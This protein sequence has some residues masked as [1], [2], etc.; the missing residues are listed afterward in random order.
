MTSLR[1]TVSQA[2]G[3]RYVIE[4]ELGRG[5][6]A[7]VFLARDVK[8]RRQVAVKVL[9]QDVSAVLGAERFLREIEIAAG[10]QHP[11]ILPLHDS[12]ELDGILFYVMP[13]VE[14]ESLRSRLAREGTL[15]VQDALLITREVA[16]ALAYAHERRVIHRDIKPENILL[17]GPHAVVADF[18]IAR[19]ITSAGATSITNTGIVVGTP[20]YMSPEQ[21]AGDQSLDGRADIYA[22]GC[23]LYECLTGQPP[24]SGASAAAVLAQQ[25]TGAPPDVRRT[26]SDVSAAIQG[27]L[28][29]ALAKNPAQRFASAADFAAALSGGGLSTHTPT[30]GWRARLKTRGAAVAF[31]AAVTAAAVGGAYARRAFRTS[32]AP[33]HSLAVIPFENESPER[34]NEYFADGM[35]EELIGAFRRIAG[36]RVPPRSS[37]FAFKGS[38]LSAREVGR[39]LKVDMVLDGSVVRSSGLV[40]VRAELVDVAA[41]TTI[42][43]ESYRDTLADPFAVQDTLASRIVARLGPRLNSAA[44]TSLLRRGTSDREAYLLYLKGRYAMVPRT[45]EGL[46][47]A[48]D[49]FQQAVARD[50][51]Y[52]LAYSGLADSYGLVAGYSGALSPAE[53]FGRARVAANRALSLDAASPE[54]H[55]SSA[56]VSLFHDYDY[57]AAE[58]ELS[59]AERL[60]STYT[61]AHVIA[62]WLDAVTQKPALAV[63]ELQTARRLEPV[64]VF[65]NTRLGSVMY[66]AGDVPGAIA[67]LRRALEIDS[68]F[69]LAHVELARSLASQGKVDEALAELARAPDFTYRYEAA[70][71]L[72]ALARAGRKAEA[73]QRLADRLAH[74]R[75]SHIDPV[76]NALIYVGLGE[77]EEAFKWL[78]SAKVQ[79]PWSMTLL[80]VEPLWAPVAKDPRFLA[81]LRDF[82][83]PSD[84]KASP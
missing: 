46:M 7:T 42:W 56:F 54:A 1:E 59:A 45:H 28:H 3:D 52:T 24:F 61:F 53:G 71:V 81:V 15:S 84:A 27:A 75:Q 58:R 32:S 16:D 40:R 11:H 18:G 82:R 20:A 26:R 65:V 21:V 2:I 17:S 67:Q 10:L 5:G 68:T 41:D 76:G 6:M 47:R 9:R 44:T 64:S 39:R 12:G 62:G 51:T 78:D 69:T 13:Y 72:Y 30:R 14:G 60:D 23:V 38:K 55:T 83:L 34:E 29:R 49:F 74:A 73:R 66:Y 25:L 80:A 22:L 31:V 36:L 70:P 57:A 33:I 63:R 8:H 37:V 43:A 4:R 19:A 48:I 50:T 77:T 79:R 35:T